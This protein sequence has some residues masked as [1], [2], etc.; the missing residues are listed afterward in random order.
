[1]KKLASIPTLC[2]AILLTSCEAYQYVTSDLY[3]PLNKEKNE[4][5]VSGGISTLGPYKSLLP[6]IN[7]QLG[8]TLTNHFSIF[9]TGNLC[10]TFYEN[11]LG[12][13]D[14][15]YKFY[16]TGNY[17][18]A[19]FNLGLSYFYHKNKHSFEI[20]GAGG[21]GI[22][23]YDYGITCDAIEYYHFYMYEKKNNYYIQPVYSYSL[24][25][26]IDIGLFSRFLYSHYYDIVS[27][28]TGESGQDYT[29]IDHDYYKKQKTAD[30][31]IIEPGLF[32]RLKLKSLNV[33][34]SY[35][36]IQ[37]INNNLFTNEK[38]KIRVSISLDPLK[39]FKKKE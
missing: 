10:G 9:G 33:Q 11:H 16:D 37:K 4:L 29:I 23:S 28:H 38:E 30:F 12:D 1:M 20:V 32:L 14:S 5:N 8:Y 26:S 15:D 19:E 36:Y 7:L 34:W 24:S 17:S 31:Y 27:N 18:L 35:S 39:F 25:K 13:D 6:A 3:I 22:G 21:L 2:I